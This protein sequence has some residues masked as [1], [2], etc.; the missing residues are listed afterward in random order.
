MT[1]FIPGIFFALK[2]T[3]SDI[4]LAI[5]AFFGLVLSLH[6]FSMHLLLTYCVL[7]FKVGYWDFPGST[8]VKNSPPNAGDTGLIPGQGTRSHVHGTTKSSYATTK[9][10]TGRN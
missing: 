6:T 4:N 10:P 5:L 3:L 1:L 8:V 2:S 7:I 9:E